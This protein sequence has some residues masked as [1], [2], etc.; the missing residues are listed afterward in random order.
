M[1][2]LFSGDG[3]DGGSAVALICFAFTV[4]SF[5]FVFPCF[6]SPYDD[7]LRTVLASPSNSGFGFC[8]GFFFLCR[9]VCRDE[10]NSG[11]NSLCILDSFPLL[12][13]V[14]YFFA[15]GFLLLFWLQFSVLD[16][17]FFWVVFC[18]LC[19]SAFL[20]QNPP[21]FSRPFSGF[22]KAREGLVSLPPQMVGIVEARDHD[23]IV[24]IVA[25][26]YWI[27]PC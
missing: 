25:M 14:Y 8:V 19:F 11:N 16:S 27:F 17:I 10:G 22:Y 7:E 20:L 23:R 15:P 24:G 21:L 18:V 12:L 1:T 9:D 13:S 26:I 5:F 3:V 2:Y 4:L 6:L